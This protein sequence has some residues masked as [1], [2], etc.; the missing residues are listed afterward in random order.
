MSAEQHEGHRQRVADFVAREWNRLVGA[1][2]SWIDDEADRDAEDIVQD[3]M[4][5]LFSRPDVTAPIQDLSAFVW[6][7]LRNRVVDRYRVR[8]A[9]VSLDSPD[10]DGDGPRGAAVADD[11]SDADRIAG[12]REL[13]ERIDAAIGDLGDAERAVFLAT[14]LEGRKFRE[15]AAEWDTPIGTLLARKHRAVKRLRAALADIDPDADEG[16]P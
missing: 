4:E 12:Q 6:Q 5:G 16:G 9:I 8:R 2:R 1:V 13:G 14:E 10:D 3:V 11:R 7:S 15:L